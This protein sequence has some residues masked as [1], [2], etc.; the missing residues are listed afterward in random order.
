MFGN[1]LRA[2]PHNQQQMNWLLLLFLSA[3]RAMCV[4]EA[5]KKGKKLVK[6]ENTTEKKIYMY[7]YKATRLS[8]FGRIMYLLV[9]HYFCFRSSKKI[10]D[11]VK[12]KHFLG[13]IINHV[14]RSQDNSVRCMKEKAT[15]NLS[16]LTWKVKTDPF[17][18]L[19]FFFSFCCP[20]N[21]L[22]IL[23]SWWLSE[24]FPTIL[25]YP[26]DPALSGQ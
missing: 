13:K 11:L 15:A 22:N 8:C 4:L 19:L 12:L 7:M 10:D 21:E 5:K 20:E 14:C 23:N 2:F 25:F 16:F 24:S 3:R 9:L 18:F 17:L 1:N 26:I 6:Q